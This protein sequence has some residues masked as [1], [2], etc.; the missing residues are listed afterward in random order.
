[1]AGLEPAR[2][3]YSL[4]DCLSG[5]KRFTHF[6]LVFPACLPRRFQHTLYHAAMIPLPKSRLSMKDRLRIAAESLIGICIGAGLTWYTGR[7]ILHLLRA[8][9]SS[10]FLVSLRSSF[11]GILPNIGAVF[12]FLLYMILTFTALFV[13]FMGLFLTVFSLKRFF[14]GLAGRDD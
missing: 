6:V 14:F 2:A 7:D 9:W 1:M 4:T 12:A 5:L 8:S 3:N 11:H 13:T 10:S